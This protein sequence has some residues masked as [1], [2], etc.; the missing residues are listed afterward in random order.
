MNK[1][2]QRRRGIAARKAIQ[3]AARSAYNA[4]ICAG[5][6]SSPVYQNARTLLS[7]RAMPDEVDLS[8]LDTRGK[9]V[10]YPR[11]EGD[12]RMRALVPT[13]GAYLKGAFGIEE[14]DPR[15]SEELA[16]HEIDLVLVPC[17]AFDGAGG[18][19][20]MGGGYYDRYLPG[21]TGAF[22]LLVAFEAQRTPAVESGA[23]DVRVDGA[24][25]EKGVFYFPRK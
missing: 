22:K 19:V 5:I 11:C 4:A 20:G 1:H 3:Q 6:E 23:L 2:E 8:G 12:R 24:V 17:A 25:T 9:L 18:R 7:Y 13:G 21:C 16:P 14:P 15:F 10:A